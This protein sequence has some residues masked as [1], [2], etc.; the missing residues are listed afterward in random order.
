MGNNHWGLWIDTQHHY[1]LE[2]IIVGIV[3]ATG[4]DEVAVIVEDRPTEAN[5][6]QRVGIIERQWCWI[7]RII[8]AQHIDLFALSVK[9]HQIAP[10]TLPVHH[11]KMILDAVALEHHGHRAC[12]RKQAEV[13]ATGLDEAYLVFGVFHGQQVSV[14]AG[15]LVAD[16]NKSLIRGMS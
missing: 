9:A 5:V 12:G 4:K 11:G 15:S 14:V 16:E 13:G 3:E 2:W 7:L 8:H 10:S 6:G 1:R